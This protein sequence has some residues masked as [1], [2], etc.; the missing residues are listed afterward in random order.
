MAVDRFGDY[1]SFDS[2]VESR[3]V[4]WAKFVVCKVEVGGTGSQ[5][6]IW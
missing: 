1:V 6:L 5:A 4:V 3:L 2:R